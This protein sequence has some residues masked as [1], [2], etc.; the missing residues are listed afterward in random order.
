[1]RRVREVQ[2][3]ARNPVPRGTPAHLAH[4]ARAAHL[5]RY[6]LYV[7]RSN[8]PERLLGASKGVYDPA[9]HLCKAAL[10]LYEARHAIHY[11][12]V[13]VE[14][15]AY[16]CEGAILV[17]PPGHGKTDL[18]RADAALRAC[19]D[20]LTQGFMVHAIKERAENNLQYIQS[21]FDDA[22]PEGRR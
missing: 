11:S 21:L 15:N 12:A 1:I 6:M 17:M 9:E 7:G 13:G 2:E 5:L 14:V 18:I 3:K 10:F 22:K 4:A 16:R 20:P 19:D 8:I